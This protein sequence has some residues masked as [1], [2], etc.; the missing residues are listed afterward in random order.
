MHP[1]FN[2]TSGRGDI[3]LLQLEHSI[4]F[5]E[6]VFQT[7]IDPQTTTKNCFVTEWPS[8]YDAS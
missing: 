5:S 6:Y 8:D 4:K 7:C 2:K 1:G 3:M